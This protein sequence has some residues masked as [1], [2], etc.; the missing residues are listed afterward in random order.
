[1]A[2]SGFAYSMPVKGLR[3]DWGSDSLELPWNI[4]IRESAS[5]DYEERKHV[6]GSV[7]GYWDRGSSFSG[8]YNTKVIKLCELDRVRLARMVGEHPGAIWVRDGYGKAMN[9]TSSFPRSES[10]T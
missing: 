7:N 2:W 3:F 8:S 9:A 5:K 4:E 10:T 6:D 1:M